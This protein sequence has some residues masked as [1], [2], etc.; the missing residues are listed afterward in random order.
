M[1]LV[2]LCGCVS[3]QNCPLGQGDEEVVR[4]LFIGNS[5]TY[6]NDLPGTF[7]KLA[8][9]GGHT[10][11]V[12]TAAEGGWTLADHVGSVETFQKLK[13][14]HW[15]FVVLQEQS[16]LPAIDYVRD[17]NMYP[18]VRKLA[19]K[20]KELG[21]Q[22]YL[23][24]T[25]GHRDGYPEGYLQNYS[26]MQ[27]QLS[28]GYKEIADELGLPIAPVGD[29]WYQAVTQHDLTDLWQSDGSHPSE[30]GTYLAVCVFY[31]AIF[32]ESP[33]GLSYRGGVTK[34]RARL[35]QTL[36]ANSILK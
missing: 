21:A 35:L 36:A 14:Q 29:A 7:Q 5:Y 13:E 23:F 31:A 3:G 15:D 19:A 27:Y 25:W 30:Q 26:A 22:P 33:E 10:V 18:A 2:S 8:C 16:V 6:V 24:L 11:E 1:L 9:A 4:I 28:V 32:Q 12:S 34:D 17:Q 20:I